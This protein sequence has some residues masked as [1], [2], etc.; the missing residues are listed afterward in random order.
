[1]KDISTLVED[2]YAVVENKG[3]WDKVVEEA[4]VSGLSGVLHSRFNGED[5][6]G[7]TLRLSNLGTPCA[8]KLWFSVNTPDDREALR[9]NTRLK[10]LY[11]DVLEQ[12]LIALAIAAGH[13]V[14]GT[15]DTLYVHGIKGHRDC[16]IDGVTVDIKS[17]APQS[18]IKFAKGELRGNDP[19]GYISQL[20]SYVYAGRDDP[21]VTDKS[22]GAFLVIDKVNGHIC[23]D[24]YDFSGELHSKEAEIE[25]LKQMV[26]GDTPEVPYEDVADGK[27]GNRK[28]PTVCSYCDFKKK[29]WP[30][31]RVFLYSTGPRFLTVV[32]REPDVPEIYSEVVE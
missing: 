25:D 24:A 16:V 6:G 3:G 31:M 26:A 12:L 9:P 5:Q 27:S 20:S 19:F 30:G 28:L 32:E 13:R 8:R 22:T 14:E 15:Q 17:A 7:G 18:F 2:I 23:L 4:F 10:F 11:G 1:M 29:C 21:L